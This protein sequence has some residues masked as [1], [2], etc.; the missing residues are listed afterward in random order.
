MNAL[1]LTLGAVMKD[2]SVGRRATRHGSHRFV[3]DS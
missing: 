3:R 2:V 1:N